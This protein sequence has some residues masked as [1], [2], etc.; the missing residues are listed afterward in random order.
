M[1]TRI[2]IDGFKTFE[3]FHLDLGPFL[4]ILGPNACGKS[5]LF[6]AMRLLSTL[7]TLD[8]RSAVQQ[9]RGEPYELFRRAGDGRAGQKMAFAV[10][11][12]LEPRVRDPWGAE[13]ELR[14]TR[15][16][17]ELTIEL[18]QERGVERLFVTHE[19]VR[20]ILKKDDHLDRL[21]GYEVSPRFLKTFAK[22]HRRSPFLETDV[23]GPRPI[24]EIHNDGVQGRNSH[25]PADAAEA[26]V[27]SSITSAEYRHLYALREEMRSWCFLQLNPTVMRRASS[28]VAPEYLEA[29]GNNLATVLARIRALTT[30]DDRPKGVIADIA[31][32]LA[33]LIPSV[34]ALEIKEDIPNREFYLE[35]LQKD[36]IR[37]SSR[38][39]SDGTLRV[40]AL[41][42]M[43]HDPRRRGLICLEEPE[44]GV[45]PIRLKMLIARL[46][47]LS[48][49]PASDQDATGEPLAQML[50]NSHSPV[51]LS[52]LPLGRV[53]FADMVTAIDPVTK[54]S[55]RRTRL[56]FVE[57][58]LP[59]EPD[60]PNKVS[61][62]EVHQIL[63]TVDQGASA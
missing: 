1:L 41:L 36:G 5:N 16:R 3:R 39:V 15:L 45:H 28:T 25:R 40:L 56:R 50:L 32:D 7:T 38:V 10:E 30:T 23:S 6:D 13:V 52:S 21:P 43:L 57:D 49:D 46:E 2:E 20:P 34:K 19:A 17:Y 27:L 42:T 44:N 63:E 37:F 4:V 51:V 22:Y 18:R 12:L 54:Q 55:S 59:L 61:S 33:S 29:D 60:D 35:I 53:V 8:L 14:S 62:Y 48:T 9:M 58:T 11:V 31:A 47:E 24:L 26:T